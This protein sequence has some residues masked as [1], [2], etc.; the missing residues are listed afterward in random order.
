MRRYSARHSPKELVGG[1]ESVQ[2]ALSGQRRDR[3]AGSGGGLGFSAT[4]GA[5]KGLG[6]VRILKVQVI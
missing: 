3:A 4:P 2:G 5:E 1:E 6:S